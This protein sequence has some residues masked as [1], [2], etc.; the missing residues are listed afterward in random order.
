[1]DP[2]K[3][4]HFS[5]S[6]ARA[7]KCWE[8]N[9]RCGR[10]GGGEVFYVNHQ[11]LRGGQ[12]QVWS[13]H[14]CFSASEA[15]AYIRIGSV[16]RFGWMGKG[17]NLVQSF[18]RI[19]SSLLV[20]WETTFTIWTSSCLACVQW[21]GICAPQ[22]WFHSVNRYICVNIGKYV[23]HDVGVISWYSPFQLW[24]GCKKGRGRDRGSI[25]VR[26]CGWRSKAREFYKSLKPLP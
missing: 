26:M 6:C 11:R 13:S 2:V 3:N 12:L 22:I 14:N 10:K 8:L 19:F 5:I 24:S 17:K 9:L 1:M 16:G 7:T 20:C 15:E 18:W 4:I 21:R 23:R 25:V